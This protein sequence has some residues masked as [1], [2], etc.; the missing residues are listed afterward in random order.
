MAFSQIVVAIWMTNR[1]LFFIAKPVLRAPDFSLYPH[2][3]PRTRHHR[4]SHLIHPHY[5]ATISLPPSTLGLPKLGPQFLLL[6][7]PA[8]IVISKAHF[9]LSSFL[10]FDRLQY[11]SLSSKV[12]TCSFMGDL[13]WSAVGHVSHTLTQSRETLCGP[14][15]EKP[16]LLTAGMTLVFSN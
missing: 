4:S 7:F 10:V 9:L 1:E 8:L 5:F 13:T 14:E 3:F 2:R 15:Q 12:L 6:P 16:T 11:C